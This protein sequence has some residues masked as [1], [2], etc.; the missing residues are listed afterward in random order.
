MSKERFKVVPAVYVVIRRGDEVLLLQRANTGYMDGKY[1]LPAGHVDGDEPAIDAAVREAEEE[2]G[3]RLVRD[4]LRLAHVMHRQA[5]NSD[6]DGKHERVDFFFEVREWSGEPRNNEPHKC[7]ELRWAPLAALPEA[8]V[9][10]V[11]LALKNIVA[12][13]VYSDFNFQ[14]SS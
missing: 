1:S 12:G 10:E 6:R 2:V 7:S 3:V 8:M 13:K 11:R 9:P 14:T 5:D 4:K